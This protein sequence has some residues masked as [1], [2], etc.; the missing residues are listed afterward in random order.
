MFLRA[1]A[2]LAFVLVALLM[3]AGLVVFVPTVTAEG[4]TVSDGIPAPPPTRYIVGFHSLPSGF[5]IG[6]EYLGGVVLDLDSLRTWAWVETSAPS[7]FETAARA[8]PR[9]WS[10][11]RD[12]FDAV[13]FAYTPNDPEW[14]QQ[15]APRQIRADEAWDL[16]RGSAAVEVC[17]VD[18][19]VDYNHV[20]LQGSRWKGGWN[21]I[22]NNSDPMDAS[23][24]S[25]GTFVTGIIAATINNGKNISGLAQVDFSVVKIPEG[26]LWPVGAGIEWCTDREAEVINLSLETD[27]DN[28]FVRAKVGE[29]WSAG[30]LLVAAAGNSPV[31]PEDPD[32]PCSQSDCIA[33][34]A[35]YPEVIAVTS[36]DESEDLCRLSRF[37]PEAELAA[38]GMNITSLTRNNG[39]QLKW[40][41]ATSWAAAHVTGVT[42]L[43][44]SLNPSFT[45]QQIRDRLNNTAE[46]IGVPWKYGHGLVDTCRAAGPATLE[47]Y[48]RDQD[49]GY[50]ILGVTVTTQGVQ[51]MTDLEGH[52][53]FPCLQTGSWTVKFTHL[54]YN[55]RTLWTTL[56][57][58]PNWLNT[59]MKSKEGGGPLMPSSSQGSDDV[60]YMPPMAGPHSGPPEPP[61]PTAVL[62]VVR[63]T[64]AARHFGTLEKWLEARR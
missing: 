55:S 43:V 31:P 14:P 58:G 26:P 54:L 39:T 42:A 2:H 44:K 37:G 41:C 24:N 57:W 10:L 8:D 47:G 23:L 50:G 28:A 34:P 35:K 45:N 25:H 48:V 6:G 52:Y 59:S 7:A 64:N 16:T 5:Q 56:E 49:T 4:L 3:P 60:A 9:V 15:W 33:Y 12:D 32:Y 13:R 53:F 19:G 22:D 36:V 20:D 46:D 1:K 18:S 40:G 29:A 30:V 61:L 51:R 11:D 17:I 21:Y 38:P 62:A 63:T 27:E